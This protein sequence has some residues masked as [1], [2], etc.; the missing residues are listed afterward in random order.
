[1]SQPASSLQESIKHAEISGDWGTVA[2]WCEAH[3]WSHAEQVPANEHL[4]QR[5]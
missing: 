1:M 4:H 5:T 3:D 2:D